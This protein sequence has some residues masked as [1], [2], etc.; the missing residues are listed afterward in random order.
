[1][2]SGVKRADVQ[3]VEDE[4]VGVEAAPAARRV[5]AKAPGSTTAR[6]A[7]HALGLEARA[8][9]GQRARR[10]RARSGSR[11]PARRRDG[12]REDALA[13]RRE[14]RVGAASTSTAT[15]RACGAHT[16]KVVVPSPAG[17]APSGA[18]P[19][20]RA[21]TLT[22]PA[23]ARSLPSGGSITSAEADSP[24]HG[25]VLGVHA[26]QVA[27]IRAAVDLGVGVQ[28][29]APAARRGASAAR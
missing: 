9:V 19:G 13:L 11:R 14:R 22:H 25:R 2:P 4:L 15:R 17:V 24:P 26:A 27:Q 6:G 1:M 21:P 7:A 8:G 28:H 5:Q 29:L 20:S 18:L 23:S 10:R 3:L 12:A 16:R